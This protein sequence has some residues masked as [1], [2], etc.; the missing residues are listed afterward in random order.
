M[1]PKIAIVCA[2]VALVVG[3]YMYYTRYIELGRQDDQNSIDTITEGAFAPK[4]ED[5]MKGSGT[6]KSLLGLGKNVMC[7][8]SYMQRELNTQVNGKVYASDEKMRLNFMMQTNGQQ[9]ETNMIN[10]GI[11]MYLWGKTEGG[12]MAM[13]FTIDKTETDSK[14]NDQFDMNTDVDYSCQNWNVDAS[15]FIPPDNLTFIDYNKNI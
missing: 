5:S 6:F 2:F 9:T 15:L 1:I 11:E 12:D 3:G 10:D 14:N 4:T 7:D 13:K 8:V